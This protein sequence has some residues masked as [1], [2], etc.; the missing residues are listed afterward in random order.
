LSI[1]RRYAADY[2]VAKSGAVVLQSTE[3]ENGTFLELYDL[4]YW[5]F[6]LNGERV[7]NA[8]MSVI[9]GNVF[10]FKADSHLNAPFQKRLKNSCR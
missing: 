4:Y 1:I 2:L 5:T 3:S 6:M 7:T 8:Q 10:A 9:D